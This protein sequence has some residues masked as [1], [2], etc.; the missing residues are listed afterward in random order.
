MAQLAEAEKKFVEVQQPTENIIDESMIDYEEDDNAE[1][2]T[3]KYSWKLEEVVSFP[4]ED[5]KLVDYDSVDERLMLMFEDLTLRECNLETKQVVKELNIGD[6]DGAE[7][8]KG[9]KAVAFS[10]FKDLNTIAVATE[11]YVHLFDYE[12]DLTLVT[13][14]KVSNVKQVTFCEVYVILV[15][16]TEDLDGK[17]DCY[18]LDEEHPVGTLTVKSFEGRKIIVKPGE[19]SIHYATGNIVGR[20]SV[21]DMELMFQEETETTKEIL[22]FAI[23]DTCIFTTGDDTHLRIFDVEN[24]YDLIAPMENLECDVMAVQGIHLVTRCGG[25]EAMLVWK[26]TEDGE[27]L[28]EVDYIEVDDN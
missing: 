17:I 20:I 10:M 16:E 18:A 2:S 26:F 28:E 27:E 25:G 24:G 15:I 5:K 13:K 7:E 6:L 11:N 14:L 1:V 4:T 23:A 8:I 3:K 22:D 9:S 12:A 21:P 19:Q